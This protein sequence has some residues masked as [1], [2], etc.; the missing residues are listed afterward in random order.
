VNSTEMH[1]GL[2]KV[3]EF[4]AP[5]GRLRLGC[6]L[7][8]DSLRSYGFRNILVCKRSSSDFGAQRRNCTEMHCGLKDFDLNIV[9]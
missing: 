6:R 3:I 9:A 5:C 2:Q 1:S 4:E 8:C 7:V